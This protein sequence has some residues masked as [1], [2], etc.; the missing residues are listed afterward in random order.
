MTAHFWPYSTGIFCI[1]VL[2]DPAFFIRVFTPLVYVLCMFI[3]MV[4]LFNCDSLAFLQLYV[5]SV[6]KD[7]CFA[8][9]LF[10]EKSFL[11]NQV[12]SAMPV[13]HVSKFSYC[14]PYVGFGFLMG[15]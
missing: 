5:K 10:D 7:V 8:A 9:H 4:P 13:V 11:I 1:I 14:L 2:S 15:S 12:F 3:S 6:L